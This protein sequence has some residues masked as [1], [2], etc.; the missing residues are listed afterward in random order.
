MTAR[1][2]LS[3]L[4]LVTL[5]TTLRVP[6]A[7]A[8]DAPSLTALE[9]RHRA[10]L[11]ATRPDLASRY[12]LGGE[13]RLEPVTAA[14]LERDAA[15]ARAFAA[16]LE[17]VDAARLAPRERPRLDSLRVRVAR[18]A[19]TF[20]DGAWRSEP[21]FYLALVHDAVM[22]A[23]LAPRI[24]PCERARRAVMRLRMVPEVLRAGLINLRA[25][26][27]P[28]PATFS[29]GA[30]AAYDSAAADLRTKLLSPV[31]SCKDPRRLADLVAADT[32]AL[33]A[34]AGFVADLGVAPAAPEA[35]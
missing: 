16:E 25:S 3:L 30:A 17:H 21:T 20:G 7:R 18:E 23:I 22:E 2:P 5:C 24:S 31:E 28:S 12:G 15:W 33:H 19:A 34:Y 35:R 10:H 14:T 29:A 6:A 1:L 27:D 13:D 32:L 4:L 26:G 8:A 9:A 11:L